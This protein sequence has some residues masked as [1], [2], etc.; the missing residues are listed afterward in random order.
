MLSFSG[1][2]TNLYGIDSSVTEFAKQVRQII[3]MRKNEQAAG[4]LRI[5]QDVLNIRRD[6]V[7][8]ADSLSE[9]IAIARQAAGAEPLAT[10]FQRAGKNRK[11]AMIDL[12]RD[13]T[14]FCNF[15][16]VTDQT[17]PGNI[18]HGVNPKFETDPGG[19]SI[20]LR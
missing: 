9:K 11:L 1:S 19:G 10:V 17:K 16:S 3:R 4:C 18:R 6:T 2:G 7:R 20:Q 5:K 13:M 8:N 12:Q 15:Q 14:C